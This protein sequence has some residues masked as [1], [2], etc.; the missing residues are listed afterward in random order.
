M[1]STGE[2]SPGEVP[3]HVRVAAHLEEIFRLVKSDV[4]KPVSSATQAAD[5]L[6]SHISSIL[7]KLHNGIPVTE[8]ALVQ[9]L[10]ALRN[11]L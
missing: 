2:S 7:H 4:E 5:D 6:K 1:S 3:L 11:L 10:E 8:G 9:K